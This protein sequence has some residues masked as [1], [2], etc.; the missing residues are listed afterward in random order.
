MSCLRQ[1]TG[2]EEMHPVMRGKVRA[3]GHAVLTQFW[4]RETVGNL[5]AK[6]VS[7]PTLHFFGSYIISKN[8]LEKLKINL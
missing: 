7:A 1:Q 6:C 8:K 3:E 4:A 2:S 5:L